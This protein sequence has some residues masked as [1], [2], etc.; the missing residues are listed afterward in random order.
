MSGRLMLKGALQEKRQ[1]DYE[2]VTEARGL[3]GSI[4]DILGEAVFRP[5]AD[6]KVPE[7]EAMMDRLGALYAEHKSLLAEIA[8][9]EREL[10]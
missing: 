10:A 3:A 7:A 9:I 5:L 1:R 8:E 6:V 2:V 4:R